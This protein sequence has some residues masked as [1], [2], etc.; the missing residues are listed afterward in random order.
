MQRNADSFFIRR[1]RIMAERALNFV[2]DRGYCQ[3]V[4]FAHIQLMEFSKSFDR[5][6]DFVLY[7]RQKVEIKIM[8]YRFTEEDCA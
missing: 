6:R 1:N 7:S 3:F 8:E 5:F 4:R 2:S